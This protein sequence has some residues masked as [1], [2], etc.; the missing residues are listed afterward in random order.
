MV[1]VL[2]GAACSFGKGAEDVQ[3]VATAATTVQP[4]EAPPGMVWIPGGEFLMGGDDHYAAEAER[5]V[6]RVRVDGFFLDVHTVTNA[7]FRAFV[8]ATGYVTIA[9]RAPDV[10]E[11][12]RQLPPGTSPPDAT[13]LVPGSLVFVPTTR[14]VNLRDWSEWWDWMPGA[15]WRHPKGPR[16]SIAGQD[17]YPVVH[18]AWDDAVAYATW[19]GRRIPTEAEWEF[20]AR[21]GNRRTFHPW[22]DEPHDAEHP[23]AHIYTGTFPTHDA[24]PKPVGAFRPTAFGLYD[25]A[26]NVWQW[27]GDWYRPDTYA[28]DAARGLVFNPTGPETWLDPQREGVPSR[29]VRGGSFLC[30]DSYCRGYRVSARS[31][32]APDSGA[33][34]IGF[35]T[36]MTVAQW[37]RW[38]AAQGTPS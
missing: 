35:R 17:D 32:G 7:Q 28:I 34:H 13:Q 2:L 22:G 9:E 18:V 3:T 38:K 31:P 20:A 8:D 25:M 29:V 27:T 6:H 24:A 1:A 23:Q 19:A 37:I 16:S 4:G 36:V 15:N 10:A 26:G 5:P 30:S 11:L 33:S 12:M 21:G 14:P